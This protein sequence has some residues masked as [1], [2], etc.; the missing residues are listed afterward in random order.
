VRSKKVRIVPPQYIHGGEASKAHIQANCVVAAMVKVP[1]C[2]WI[3]L[4]GLCKQLAGSRETLQGRGVEFGGRDREVSFCQKATGE[5]Q[6]V[7]SANS[8]VLDKSMSANCG[9][10]MTMRV[11]VN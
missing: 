6:M 3:D 11:E 9:R 10:E 7:T 5:E 2:Y 1:I 4:K 8:P